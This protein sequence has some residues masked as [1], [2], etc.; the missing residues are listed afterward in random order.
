MNLSP[1]SLNLFHH[2]VQQFI[3]LL[4]HSPPDKRVCHQQDLHRTRIRSLFNFIKA[5]ATWLVFCNL[6]Q[7]A[8]NKIHLLADPFILKRFFH[9][10]TFE[11]LVDTIL[12]CRV[13]RCQHHF[14]PHPSRQPLVE[15]I[16][17]KSRT[18]NNNLLN[19]HPLNISLKN[20]NHFLIK[21]LAHFFLIV[22]FFN[23]ALQL[24]QEFAAIL[25]Q[26]G[27]VGLLPLQRAKQN[28]T[29]SLLARF[30]HVPNLEIK[31]A[32]LFYLNDHINLN[33]QRVITSMGDI[34]RPL[35]HNAIHAKTLLI[36]VKLH[37]LNFDL[38]NNRLPHRAAL[39]LVSPKLYLSITSSL[40]DIPL[41]QN[42]TKMPQIIRIVYPHFYM[43]LLKISFND[44]H[45]LSAVPPFLK[46]F[47]E[48]VIKLE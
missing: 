21:I 12:T 39:L 41:V 18:S 35:G 43:T 40:H 25:F 34:L 22:F 7:Q 37:L 23:L 33:I 44:A 38:D 27:K 28:L 24:S 3:T 32:L 2:I 14:S 8:L 1:A 6:H 31:K 17:P 15:L 48:S 10:L 13:A 5:I 46:A 20:L 36:L 30:L 4:M 19:P 47:A 26:Q 29:V 11:H 9:L 42:L 45:L 16:L